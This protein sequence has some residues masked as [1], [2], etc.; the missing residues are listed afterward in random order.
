MLPNERF[1]LNCLHKY[2]TEGGII[3]SS[4]GVF[5]HCPVPECEGGVEGFYLTFE[6]H[7]HQGLMQSLDF[8]RCCFFYPD[9]VTWLNSSDVWPEKFFD[10]WDICDFFFRENNI[11][12]SREYWSNVRHE[13]SEQRS[14]KISQAYHDKPLGEK[15]KQLRGL[16]LYNQ[17]LPKEEASARGA[18]AARVR[19][20][21]MSETRKKERSEKA[22]LDNNKPMEVSFPNGLT[23]TYPSGNVASLFT[24]IPGT[25]LR[26]W[27][28]CGSVGKYGNH[29]GYSARYI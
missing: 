13:E 1:A 26:T 3:D 28:T 22:R 4:N 9:V 25:T 24:G 18:K 14:L 17:N 19:E 2:A 6:D 12:I 23:G 10:L 8:D 11:R 15:E 16:K 29:K 7:Q 27:A 5:A 20:E 21:K